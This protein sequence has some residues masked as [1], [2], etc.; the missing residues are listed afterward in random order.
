ML[1]MLFALFLV[2][3]FMVKDD[4]VHYHANFALYVNGQQE[5]FESPL[6]YEEI[7]ACSAY[8]HADPKHRVHMHDKN[9]G[10]VHVHADGVTWGHFF[11][12]LGFVLS[13]NLIETDNGIFVDDESRELTFYLN[14]K[15]VDSVANTAIQSEDVLLIDYGNSSDDAIKSEYSNISRDAPEANTAKDPASCS[16]NELTVKDR[17]IRA[18][19]FWQ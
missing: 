7:A 9:S 14:G 10:L 2:R 16:G 15:E 4:S 11:A 1:I 5:K 13:K 17:T 12:N 18:L 8:G 3:Y 19:K 6:F